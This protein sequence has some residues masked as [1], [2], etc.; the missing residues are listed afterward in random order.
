M[1]A[2]APHCIKKWEDGNTT[3]YEANGNRFLQSSFGPH[4]WL[5]KFFLMI[6]NKENVIIKDGIKLQE[7]D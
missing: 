2:S 4:C 6:Q 7:V 1:S 3:V 5:N